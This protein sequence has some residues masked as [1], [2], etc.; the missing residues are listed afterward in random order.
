[1][2]LTG[3]PITTHQ[4]A[5]LRQLQYGPSIKIGIQ[6]SSAWWTLGND[7]A[8]VPL[9]LSGGQSF[10]DFPVRTVVYPSYGLEQN[11]DGDNAVLIASY[12]WTE[13][14][15]FW[16][17]LIGGFDPENPVND[18]LTALVLRDL[19][20]VHNFD[21]GALTDLVLDVFPWDWSSSKFSMG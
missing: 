7:L 12:C 1:M 13:D 6:F 14:A 20:T 3:L 19:A 4:R 10:T 15:D 2:N 5:A 21:L 16:D 17:S 8:G 18:P 9:N 11:L